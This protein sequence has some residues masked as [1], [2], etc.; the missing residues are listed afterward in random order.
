MVKLPCSTKPGGQIGAQ[1]EPPHV[2]AQV[3]FP[4][5]CL[6]VTGIPH[7]STQETAHVAAQVAFPQVCLQVTGIPHVST[8]ETAHV[9]HVAAQV[10]APATVFEVGQTA[11]LHVF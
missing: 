9:L 11:G 3:A 2:P 8:Q 7:V 1:V 4:Q 5:V 6:Q 10:A